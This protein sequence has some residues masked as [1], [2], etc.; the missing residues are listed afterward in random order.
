MLPVTPE[1]LPG[2]LTGLGAIFSAV[3]GWTLWKVRKEPP[4]AG[5]AEAVRIALAKNTEELHAMNGQFAENMR[6]FRDLIEEVKELRRSSD[7]CREHL[8]AIRDTLN[9]RP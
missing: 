3:A 7:A 4:E 9:R 8:S 5:S 1:N 6:M 2:V